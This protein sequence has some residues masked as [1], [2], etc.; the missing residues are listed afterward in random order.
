MICCYNAATNNPYKESHHPR[1]TPL[2]VVPDSRIREVGIKR[3][4]E[5]VTAVGWLEDTKDQSA[6]QL[7]K[8]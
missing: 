4:A 8:E 1:Y 5:D 7:A 2:S 6:R 3:F